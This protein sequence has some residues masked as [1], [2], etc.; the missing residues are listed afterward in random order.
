MP[1]YD[2]DRVFQPF[3]QEKMEGR[4]P[5]QQVSDFILVKNSRQAW[6]ND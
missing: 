5:I 2:V 4:C 3:L 6:A 1:S